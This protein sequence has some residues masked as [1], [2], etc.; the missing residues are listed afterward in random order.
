MTDTAARHRRLAAA[1][2]RT[3]EQVPDDRWDSPS[4]CEGWTARQVAEHVAGHPARFL[5]LVGLE[6]P[7]PDDDVLTRWAQARDALQAALDDPARAQL[8]FDGFDGR[9]TLAA[10]VERFVCLDLVVHRWDIAR[11]T[12]QDE[13]ID[14][15]DVAW[16][17]AAAASFGDMLRAEG[18]CGPEV[19]VPA[20]ADAQT[21]MLAFGGRRA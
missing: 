9:S 18:V 15:D 10:A 14:P 6:A 17:H 4:P 19:E 21:R 16:A 11:A 8:E 12:G 1:M 7:E 5:G 2:T 13:R 3:L 20:D